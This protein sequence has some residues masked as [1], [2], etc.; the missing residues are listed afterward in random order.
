MTDVVQVLV[1]LDVS[2]GRGRSTG[3]AADTLAPKWFT[4]DPG[5][6]Y[7]EEAQDLIGAILNACKLAV[8]I[9]QSASP[10]AFW[11]D[12]SER[13][14]AWGKERGFPPLL[15]GFGASLVE[16]A[17]ID[18]GCRAAGMRF[19]DAVRA[20][21]LGIDLGALHP[22]LAGGAPRDFLPASPMR[23]LTVRHTVGLSDPLTDADI[24]PQERAD[25]GLPQSL[26]SAIARYGLT[27]FKIKL[28][29]NGRA[30]VDRLRQVAAVLG[31]NVGRFAFT[32]DGN[33]FLGDV[34]ELRALWSELSHDAV[35]REFLGAGLIA[36]EQP[37][38]RETALGEE[39][40]EGLI[41]WRDR[42]PI[43]IDE[44]DAE[45]GSAAR[46]LQCGYAGTAHKN[47]KG[48]MKGIANACLIEARRRNGIGPLILTAEDL[49]NFGPVA[50]L[51]DMAVVATLGIGHAERN[52]H[53]Y[54][55]NLRA[56]P[57]AV[58]RAVLE[59]HPDVFREDGD[60]GPPIHDVRGGVLSIGSVVDAPFGC[61]PQID[62]SR[63]SPISEWRP[64]EI[65]PGDSVLNFPSRDPYLSA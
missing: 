59:A 39:A 41:A 54:F 32:L 53:H 4:K 61:A 25:D 29:A 30:A 55:G 37:L 23:T 15:Y 1:F 36:L 47:C 52:G 64:S 11:R 14:S 56:Y 17:V 12:L 42:P 51:Q 49:V 60:G 65:G 38:K 10:F 28:P 9:P 63:F 16:R 7:A 43:I 31:R 8:G 26:E 35:V 19:A 40:R 20:N 13:Q 62:A 5:Q 21:I 27:H 22:E 33:E 57:E 48:V 58:R 50:P 44:S 24:P 46:A 3:V 6:S 2:V 18:A 34:G 45:A